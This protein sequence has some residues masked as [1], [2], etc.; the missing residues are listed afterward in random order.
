MVGRLTTTGFALVILLLVMVGIE[1]E[2]PAPAGAERSDFV[3]AD[4]CGK[5]HPEIFAAWQKSAHARAS[6]SLGRRVSSRRC[7]TCHSTGEAPAGR[8][9][10]SGVECEAC[11]GPGG[12]YSPDDIMRNRTL[13]SDFGLRDLSTPEARAALCLGCHRSSTRLTP[14]DQVAAWKRIEHR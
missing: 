12:G 9:F 7:L 11:H 4:L 14:F 5:C 6:E 1:L 10:F 2:L 13:A 3:G 8:P